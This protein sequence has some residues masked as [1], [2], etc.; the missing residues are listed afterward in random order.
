MKRLLP[1]IFVLCCSFS[2][3]RYTPHPYAYFRIDLPKERTYTLLEDYPYTFEYPQKIVQIIPKKDANEPYWIDIYYPNLKTKIHCSYKTISSSQNFYEISEDTR[4]FVYKHT[5]KADA[6]DENYYEN[7]EHNTYGILYSLKGNTA[8]PMQ[9]VLTDSTKHFFRGA[10]YFE[11]SPNQDSIAPVLNFVKE[12]I[13][14]L[15]ETFEWK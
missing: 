4:S 1:I 12:D 14:R 13:L 9:F 7:P 3:K 15:I 2:C 5:I 8:S 10:L 11:A 6:I